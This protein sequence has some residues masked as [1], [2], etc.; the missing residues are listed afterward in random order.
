MKSISAQLK[1]LADEIRYT[2]NRAAIALA[3]ELIAESM[4]TDEEKE[5]EPVQETQTV[6][7]DQQQETNDAQ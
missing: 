3:I 7:I 6:D 4:K 2:N 1:D 5:P